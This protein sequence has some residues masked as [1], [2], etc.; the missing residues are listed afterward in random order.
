[1]VGPIGTS[2]RKF[3][4]CKLVLS[5][6]LVKK[7]PEEAEAYNVYGW[8][9]IKKKQWPRAIEYYNLAI[10]KVATHIPRQFRGFLVSCSFRV[11][12]SSFEIYVG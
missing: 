7:Y 5:R 2:L 1:M 3:L 4:M 11:F 8:L 6:F 9:H 10:S 12:G